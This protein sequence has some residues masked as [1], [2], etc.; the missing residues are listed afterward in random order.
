M[1]MKSMIASQKTPA[2]MMSLLIMVG[3]AQQSACSVGRRSTALNEVRP[4]CVRHPLVTKRARG[5]YR[6]GNNLVLPR[7]SASNSA[8]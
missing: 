3:S 1:V 7:A 4:R 8:R 6:M 5:S 2:M